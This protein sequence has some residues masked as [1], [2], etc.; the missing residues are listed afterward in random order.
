MAH[1]GYL[2]RGLAFKIELWRIFAQEIAPRLEAGKRKADICRKLELFGVE[3]PAGGK[4]TS[5]RFTLLVDSLA[6]IRNDFQSHA[7]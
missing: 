1:P 2:T 3:L 5:A 4:W 6:W 7:S